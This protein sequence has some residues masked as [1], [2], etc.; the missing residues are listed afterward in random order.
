MLGSAA[1]CSDVMAPET[2]VPELVREPVLLMAAVAIVI[3]P[4]LFA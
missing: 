1:V 3:A 4:V 2:P